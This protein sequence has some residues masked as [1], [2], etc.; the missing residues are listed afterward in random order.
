MTR[1]RNRKVEVPTD[2]QLQFELG[3]TTEDIEKRRREREE[4]DERERIEQ[5]ERDG[6]RR[7]SER[8][9][10]SEERPDKRARTDMD[11]DVKST[12]SRQGK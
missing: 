4:K 7:E 12:H 2:T 3:D 8:R 6:E 10:D 9:G 5:E 1:G 11:A